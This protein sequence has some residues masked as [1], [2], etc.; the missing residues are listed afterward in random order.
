MAL[1]RL[2][3]RKLD[4]TSSEEEGPGRGSHRLPSPL[5]NNHNCV[6][7]EEDA[8]LLHVVTPRQN[9]K[10]RMSQ[11]MTVSKE[12]KSITSRFSCLLGTHQY[13]CSCLLA[14]LICKSTAP[15]QVVFANKPWTT[16]TSYASHEMCG[17][18]ISKALSRNPEEVS[19][20]NIAVIKVSIFH[21][22]LSLSVF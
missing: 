7:V 4:M 15:Y 20:G 3:K 2:K 1:F 22:T 11:I 12:G 17:K 16:M 9:Q 5:S 19:D 21:V 8:D 14:R 18:S 6:A 10:L 13:L